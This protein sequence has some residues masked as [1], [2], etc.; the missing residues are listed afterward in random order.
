[1][2]LQL[3]TEDAEVGCWAIYC[4]SE[5]CETR[6]YIWIV[7]VNTSRVYAGPQGERPQLR[8]RLKD[9]QKLSLK[10]IRLAS[11]GKY[12]DYRRLSRWRVGPKTKSRTYYVHQEKADVHSV[13]RVNLVFST[14]KPELQEA[15]AQDV[16]LLMTNATNMSVSEMIE[17]YSLRWQ[18]ELFFKAEVD[19]RF[20]P[21]PF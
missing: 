14:M 11:T 19:A 10:K 20:S 17:L 5:A 16:K 21:I 4:L 2:I 12:A 18:I 3:R 13:G 1:M 8:T 7:P 6:H 15:T 9:W